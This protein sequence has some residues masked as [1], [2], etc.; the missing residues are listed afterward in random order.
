ML[1]RSQRMPYYWLETVLLSDNLDANPAAKKAWNQFQVIAG[2]INV[3]V[4]KEY[5]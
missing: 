1:F 2:L 3:S 5:L 4:D